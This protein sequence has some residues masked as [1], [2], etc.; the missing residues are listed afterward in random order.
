MNLAGLDLPAADLD[1]VLSVDTADWKAETPGIREFFGK[2]DGRVP[3]PL[4]QELDSLE[5]R[6]G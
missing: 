4:V 3:Q 5:K 2:F 6:L 1:A